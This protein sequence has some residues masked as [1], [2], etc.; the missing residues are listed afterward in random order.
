MYA[1]AA[2]A[3]PVLA[4]NRNWQPVQTTPA[5][6]AIAL[7]MKGAAVI[8]DPE[9]WEEHTL[10][11]W[12]DASRARERFAGAVLRSPRLTLAVPDVIRLTRYGRLGARAVVFS[13]RN[14]YRR[15]RHTCQYCGAQPGPAALTI[16]HVLPRSR[17]GRSDWTNCVLA[18]LACNARKADRTPAEA[19]M[20]L[21]RAPRK[22][23]WT[24][25]DPVPAAERRLSWGQF[26]SR[27]YWEVE[28][29][30]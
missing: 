26:L 25:L 13:R 19:G 24:A 5:V 20:S 23:S 29:E 14:L 8:I 16:D 4:L 18:C 22:P 9:T 7:V 17:G 30:A 3:R 2:L 21:R 10:R 15:D 11:T 27:A 1:N 28:L 12:A 6:N